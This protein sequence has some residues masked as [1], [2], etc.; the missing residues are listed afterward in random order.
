MVQGQ[1]GYYF[2]NIDLLRQAFT[3]R[4]YSEENGGEN[5]EVLEFIGDK[6]LDLAV[7][8]LLTTMFGNI[9]ECEPENSPIE[10][11]LKAPSTSFSGSKAGEFR[12]SCDEGELTKIK[13][14]MVQK[15]NLAARMDELGFSEHLR[16]GKSDIKNGVANEPS[17]K[18]DLF[19][20][21]I[22]AVALDC[23]WDF[24]EIQSA[25]EAM[26]IPEDFLANDEDDNYVRI[27]YD[28]EAQTN[29]C[30]PWFWFKEQS[31]E[32]VWYVPE[33]ENIINQYISPEYNTTRL[34]FQCKLKLLDNLPI[35]RGFGVS[36][37]E[38]RMNVCRLAYEYLCD[39]GYIR[40]M[41]IRDEI[42]NP[43]E[44]EAINQLEILARR[45]Y[46]SIP[47]YEFE[48]TYDKNG[49]PVW[50][51]EC[52]IEEEDCSFNAV[53]SSKKAAKKAAA[54]KMLMYLLNDEEDN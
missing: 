27:I 29:H 13:S 37:S 9:K 6:A 50:K 14:R 20:A 2:K 39:N 47:T 38:A 52:F 12:C 3:R 28:W 51:C 49:N 36:K 33:E 16:M 19:E 43:N 34:K 48:E 23:D 11:Y 44:E 30:L 17:V 32:L 21:V 26:L 40:E 35:F 54:F 31:Y 42:E 7:V 24:S 46:F 22:G 45:G 41:S 5:N 15:K 53:S 8:R 18:E 25:V 10:E 4:S 1:I